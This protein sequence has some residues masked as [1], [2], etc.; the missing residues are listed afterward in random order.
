MDKAKIISAIKG[1][2][3]KTSHVIYFGGSTIVFIIMLASNGICG[4]FVDWAAGVDASVAVL[5]TMVSV[6]IRNKARDGVFD[7]QNVLA[8][9]LFPVVYFICLALSYIL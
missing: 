8:G 7:W 5:L 9:M 2:F 1:F 3:Y 6:E 4:H